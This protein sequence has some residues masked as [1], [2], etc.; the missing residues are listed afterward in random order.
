[1]LVSMI[2][3]PVSVKLWST[4]M[5]GYAQADVQSQSTESGDQN[6]SLPSNKSGSID[7]VGEFSQLSPHFTLTEFS[8]HCGGKNQ[9]CQKSIPLE[10]KKLA[11]KLEIIR[12]KFYPKGLRIVDSYRCPIE[13]A[14]AESAS[15]QRVLPNSWH[16]KGKAADIPPVIKHQDLIKLG[17][18]TG[19]GW[20]K[21]SGLVVHVDLRPGDPKSPATWTYPL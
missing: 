18:F 6:K 2:T 19:V 14:R 5:T 10:A 8:C 20:N 1:M 16:V 13:N 7:P 12:T 21:A 15:G 9:G 17:L 3:V 11:E 4:A